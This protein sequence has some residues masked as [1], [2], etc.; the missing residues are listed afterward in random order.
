MK[1]P[2][3]VL[4]RHNQDAVLHERAVPPLPPPPRLPEWRFEPFLKMGK[5]LR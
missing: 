4:V 5:G 2:A 3:V 1:K